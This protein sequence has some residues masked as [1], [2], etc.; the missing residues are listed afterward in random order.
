MTMLLEQAFNEARKL[1][2]KDQ[3]ALASIILEEMLA[4]KKWAETFN[5]ST[6]ALDQLAS[7]ALKEH[8]DGK[9]KPLSFDA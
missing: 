4:E 9:T 8:G 7:E 5:T 6:E 2:S 3:D 1:D